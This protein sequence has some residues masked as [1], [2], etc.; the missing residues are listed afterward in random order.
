MKKELLLLV[1]AALFALTPA[2]GG[3]GT[4]PT[5]DPATTDSDGDGIADANDPNPNVSDD[6]DGDGVVDSEDDDRDGD[7]IANAEDPNAD[8]SAAEQDSDSDGVADSDDDDADIDGDGLANGNDASPTVAASN[9][10]S[11]E[12]GQ[13]DTVD[14]DADLDGDGVANSEDDD[15]DGDGTSDAAQV[16]DLLAG[17]YDL[18]MTVA[19]TTCE[20]EAVGATSEETVTFVLSDDGES[21][22]LE[23]SDLPLTGWRVE[24]EF[25]LSGS[26]TNPSS[27][28]CS[29]TFSEV[30][31]GTSESGS[32]TGTIET[33]TSSEPAGC[34]AMAACS[35]NYDVAGTR[36][37]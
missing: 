30:F 2:C 25:Y 7:G 16:L 4:S 15:A 21:L 9:Q 10:D 26:S 22:S 37:E 32:L 3:G 17:T 12:D 34:A 29:F 23:G 24:N 35:T 27:P 6:A 11:D 5:A 36:Q 14:P 19:E 33:S 31:T 13:V 20:D 18:D 28:S 8:V 1:T